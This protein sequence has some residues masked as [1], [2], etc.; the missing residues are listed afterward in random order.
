MPIRAKQPER[1][2]AEAFGSA[3]SAAKSRAKPFVI[4]GALAYGVTGAIFNLTGSWAN[5]AA[6]KGTLD[7]SVA[8]YL[9]KAGSNV[10]KVTLSVRD[11][12]D[13]STDGNKLYLNEAAFKEAKKAFEEY[14]TATG[15]WLEKAKPLVVQVGTE[16]NSGL[17]FTYNNFTFTNKGA[18]AKLMAVADRY[19]LVVLPSESAMAWPEMT[20]EQKTPGTY[21]TAVKIANSWSVEDNAEAIRSFLKT[22]ETQEKLVE[23]ISGTYKVR[24]TEGSNA[25]TVYQP[26]AAVP[27][28]ENKAGQAQ[29]KL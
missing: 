4:L 6:V 5:D 8:A 19:N 18:G 3:A 23:N 28:V 14:K 11:I 12:T 1:T 29:P 26:G 7:R 16:G 15:G 9:E 22:I 24:R 27:A 13:T 10:A 25:L 17:T 21:T 2:R 20:I